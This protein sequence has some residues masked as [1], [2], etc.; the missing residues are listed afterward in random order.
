M[1]LKDIQPHTTYAVFSKRRYENGSR[2]AGTWF[3]TPQQ[4][5]KGLSSYSRE[6]TGF[7]Q[8]YAYGF[9]HTGQ[10]VATWKRDTIRLQDIHMPWPEFERMKAKDEA[11]EQRQREQTALDYQESVKKGEELAEFISENRT[12]LEALGIPIPKYVGSYDLRGG[13][14]KV[15]FTQ[16]QLNDLLIRLSNEVMA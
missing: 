6:L 13:M 3:F 2:H 7:R 15:I 14:V 10:R 1:K 8:T 4:L 9:F 12:A 5:E 11:M 16:D